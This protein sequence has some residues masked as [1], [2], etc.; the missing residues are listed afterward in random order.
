MKK[1][2]HMKMLWLPLLCVLLLTGCGK[3]NNDITGNSDTAVNSGNTGSGDAAG[4][5]IATEGNDAAGA[6]NTGAGGEN[7]GAAQNGNS[8]APSLWVGT[9]ETIPFEEPEAGYQEGT[10]SYTSLGNSVYLMRTEYPEAGGATRL[11]V[12][13]YDSDTKKTE[14]YIFTLEIPDHEDGYIVSM[15]LTTN[16]ELSLKLM[17][18]DSENDYFLVRTDLQGTV[19]EVEETFP[20]AD[21]YPWNQDYLLLTRVFPLTDGS[22]IL[23]RWDEAKQASVLTRFDEETGEKKSMGTLDGDFLSALCSDEEGSLYYYS[24]TGCI[25]RWD[26][27]KD[28]KEELT[29]PL[30]KEGINIYGT[31]GLIWNKQG[32]LLLCDLRQDSA[33]LYV[34]TREKPVSEKEIRLVCVENPAGA[35]YMQRMTA[36]FSR[37]QDVPIVM[38]GLNE[39]DYTDYRNRVFAELVAG[40]GPDILFVS[41]EDMEILQDKGLLC[42][43]SEMISED[44]LSKM[45][46]GVIELGSVNGQLTGITPEIIFETVFTGNET[47]KANSWTISEFTDLLQ[48]RDNWDWPVSF[49]SD[50]ISYYTL[51]W[52]MFCNDLSHSPFLD[53]EQG[54]CSFDSQEFIDILNLC[55]KYGQPSSETRSWEE[56]SRMLREGECLAG[57]SILYDGF[58]GFS[59]TM[60]ALGDNCHII[61]FPGED[62]SNSF[63]T[64]YS[65]GY[66]AV[67]INAEHKEEIK[68]YLNFLLSY[69]KQ[70]EVYGSSVRLDVIRDSIVYDRDGEHLIQ[71]T[72][73]EPNGPIRDIPLKPDGT[74]FLEEYLEFIQNCKPDPARIP[75]LS[76]IIG[77]ELQSCFEGGKSAEDAAATIQNRIQLYLDE[78]MQ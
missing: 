36:V 45:I 26:V 59:S 10:S 60:L 12:Q 57:I 37:E 33:S 27:E 25:I 30:Y 38:E 56:R 64:G 11:C 52:M 32:E 16:R 49:S 24:S 23:S 50:R 46:P 29:T 31:A 54:K 76:E 19:L 53:L 2:I 35:D 28:V 62:G 58:Y 3:E 71:R 44:T 8:S 20:N 67:N 68:D 14:K 70:Y 40:K 66:L 47:W 18:P 41:Y 42:D 6:R 34:L 65:Q 73:V 4:G 43:L 51:F 22:V 63:I 13:V 39:S 1:R 7:I 61:G 48:G 72:T 9:K 17:K 77:A 74:S 75:Q 5:S 78:T 21:D 55:K 15:D 69:E